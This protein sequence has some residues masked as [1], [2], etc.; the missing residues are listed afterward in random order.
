MNLTRVEA[1]LDDCERHLEATNSFGTEIEAIL[2]AHVSAVIYGAFEAEVRRTLAVRVMAGLQDAHVRNFSR[3][4]SEKL[5]RSI[6]TSELAGVAGYFHRDCKTRFH[7]SLGGEAQAAWDN[8][9]NNRHGIAHEHSPAVSNMTW[10]ELKE[11][12]PKA[13]AVIKCLEASIE[14]EARDRGGR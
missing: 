13:L 4:A 11:A 8:I 14:A 6:K 1:A 7:D 12:H 9:V 3:V 10:R 5:V 2:T